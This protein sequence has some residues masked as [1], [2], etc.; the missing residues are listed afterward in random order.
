MKRNLFLAFLLLFASSINVTARPNSGFA[1]SSSSPDSDLL[2]EGVYTA[3]G[4]GYN[5][6]L[7]Q[8][9]DTGVPDLNQ[10]SI[11]NSK[12]I[13]NG[14]IFE[15]WKTDGAWR[16]Y[17]Q[18]GRHPKYLYNPS[19]GELRW[20]FVFN[21]FG[22]QVT[23]NFWIRGNHLSE[24]TGTSYGTGSSSTS[25]SSTTSGTTTSSKKCTTCDGRGWRPT[26][27]GVSDFGSNKQKWCKEC[28]S[29]VATNHWHKPCSIC[30]GKGYY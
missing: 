23:D 8:Y 24:N 21:F 10:V 26:D 14:N 5:Y 22:E 25:S 29:W 9:S 18:N 28:G 3:T 30:N 6:T 13:I 20:R 1:P 15:F 19:T 7:G 4:K 2:Y 27:E 11:Y 16:W 12:I 17:G